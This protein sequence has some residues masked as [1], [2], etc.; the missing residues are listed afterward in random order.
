MNPG[1]VCPLHGVGRCPAWCGWHE[2][3]ED[4]GRVTGQDSDPMVI[5][6]LAFLLV[7]IVVIG[8][9]AFAVTH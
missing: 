4:K 7:W 3:P 9:V 2:A 8:V 1:E 6:C 5:A